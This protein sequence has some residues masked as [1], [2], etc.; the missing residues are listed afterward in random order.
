MH[1]VLLVDEAEM[2]LLEPAVG[3]LKRVD[4]Q[5]H[6]LTRVDLVAQE[7]VLLQ[8]EAAQPATRPRDK[9]A[10]DLEHVR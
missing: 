8:V 5:S 4:Q 7:I 9:L 10:H 6:P 3:V 1:A 2:Q